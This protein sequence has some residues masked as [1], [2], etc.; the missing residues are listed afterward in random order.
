MFFIWRVHDGKD[1]GNKIDTTNIALEKYYLT[2]KQNR[3]TD[4]YK[5]MLKDFYS[6]D[7]YYENGV[8][9]VILKDENSIPTLTKF[10]YWY[11]KEYDAPEV[12]KA[13]KGEKRFNKNRR[14]AYSKDNK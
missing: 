6:E 9:K 4:T 14:V 7:I 2:F 1:K 12:L 3:L 11:Q 13:R 8:E 5:F 10:K